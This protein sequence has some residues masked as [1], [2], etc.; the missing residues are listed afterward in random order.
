MSGS[1][2]QLLIEGEL[3]VTQV[4]YAVGIDNLFYCARTVQERYGVSPS[5]Y[6]RAATSPSWTSILP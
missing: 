1:L 4:A 2:A 6:G 3:N 5:Q